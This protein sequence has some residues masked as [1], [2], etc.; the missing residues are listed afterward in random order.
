[1]TITQL[2]TTTL[3]L[4][5][6]A[7]A[8]LADTRIQGAGAT[9]PAPLYAKWVQTYNAAHPDVKI[10]YQAVGS[11]AGITGI[12]NR[13]VLFAGSDAPLTPDQEKAANAKGPHLLHLPTVAGPVVLAYNL[14]A[15]P[16]LKIDG[17]A[18][19]D[20]F[21]GKITS[22]DDPKLKAL[23]PGAALPNTPITVVHRSDGS[24]T[25]FIFTNYL[26]KISPEWSS[27]VGNA[28]AVEWPTGAAGKGSDGVAAT[29][30]KSEGAIGY[31]EWAYADKQHIPYATQ[32]NKDGKSIKGS[33]DSVQA[34]ID[35]S[36]GS[37]PP[38]FKIS[39]TDAPGDNAY[40]ICGFTYILLYDDLSYLKDKAAATQLLTFVQWCETDGQE[41]AKDLGYARL[42]KD[43]QQKVL[44]KL[45]TITFDGQPLLK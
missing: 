16:E 44:E 8:A 34:A 7:S 26:A 14:P 10:D 45:K 39:I 27:K 9:F 30:K 17:P 28:T 11:G 5:L 1:M 40:P 22:W 19:A 43:A 42:P 32:I 4:G 36:A 15:A 13:T 21:L 23:N 3:A 24:G 18:L 29:I 20:I 33:I 38:D 2:A 35:A 25:T 12:T 41:M 37:F 6:A 31:V